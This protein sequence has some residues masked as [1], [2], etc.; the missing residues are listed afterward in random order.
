MRKRII[1]L[2]IATILLLLLI[3]FCSYPAVSKDYYNDPDDYEDIWEL[4]GVL[5]L[6][7]LADNGYLAMFPTDVSRLEIKDYLCRHDQC[8]PLGEGFQLFIKVKYEDRKEFLEEKERLA[9]LDAYGKKTSTKTKLTLYMAQ[10]GFR[11]C[12]EYTLID[13]KEQTVIYIYLTGLPKK[14]IEFD[15]KYLPDNYKDYGYFPD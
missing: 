14:Q 2:I 3:K 6:S 7:K 1:T 8:L 10:D 5:E 9:A 15:H 4:E 12:Y 11:S 13:E